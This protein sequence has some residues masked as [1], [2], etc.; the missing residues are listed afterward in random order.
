M[1]KT[2]FSL[3]VLLT[4]TA[5]GKDRTPDQ[6]DAD[7]NASDQAQ[8]DLVNGT[9]V[10][11]LY[12]KADGKPIGALSVEL[13]AD[14]RIE[15]R[16]QSSVIGAQLTLNDGKS[17]ET[18]HLADGR[19]DLVNGGF[20]IE[21]AVSN[22]SLFDVQL[23]LAGSIQGDEMVGKLEA[24]DYPTY[25]GTFRLR[26]NA[27]VP[28]VDVP[29]RAIDRGRSANR[30]DFRGTATID[31]RDHA[32]AHFIYTP[33]T[34]NAD[35][36]FLDHFYPVR[37]GNVTIGLYDDDQGGSA[38]T[39]AFPNSRWDTRARTLTGVSDG[40]VPGQS[41]Y[42]IT[43]NCRETGG[44]RNPGWNCDWTGSRKISIVV[45]GKSR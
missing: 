38:V 41:P 22:P 10:G 9:Y 28:T 33:N 8:T 13:A 4:F 40:Q 39:L 27:A 35:Q 11:V 45:T 34:R 32:P 14:T 29:I 24:K 44:D 2:L 7:K 16:E 26:K 15:N 42:S 43:L 5:C 18:I 31:H 25:G 36:R 17:E 19:Y 12:A 23:A 21:A 3:L 30:S 1:K 37:A 6:Y 20:R